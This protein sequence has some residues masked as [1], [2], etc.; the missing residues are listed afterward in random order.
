MMSADNLNAL[1]TQ[2]NEDRKSDGSAKIRE[3]AESVRELLLRDTYGEERFL[4]SQ[5]REGL[6]EI[7]VELYDLAGMQVLFEM[8][9]G[10]G[11]P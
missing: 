8:W 9:V 5:V 3:V 6:D 10:E 7:S 2:K 1:A 4:G 11:T